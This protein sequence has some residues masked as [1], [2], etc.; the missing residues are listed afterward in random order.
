MLFVEPSR[1]SHRFD[2]F[3]GVQEAFID[4]HLANT[5]YRYD[6]YSL[7]F[8]IQPFNFDFRGFLFNDQ[9]LGIRLF[10]NRDNNRFQY[11]LAAFWRLE[12]DTN[13][14]LNAVLQRPRDDFLIVAN[15]YRHRGPA[16]FSSGENM[17]GFG[18]GF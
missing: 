12:K 8:G 17:G 14:G 10:G 15:V 11:N 9:Q 3:L 4:Y 2:H 18:R 7:R 16:L 13:S 5:S 6:F 1:P